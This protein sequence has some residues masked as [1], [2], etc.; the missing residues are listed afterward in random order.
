[1][2]TAC[3]V[4][5]SWIVLV[6]MLAACGSNGGS[7]PSSTA[8]AAA[9]PGSATVSSAPSSGPKAGQTDTDWGRIWDSLPPRFL[10]VPGGTPDENAAGEPVSAVIVF[11]GLQPEFAARFLQSR[12][13]NVGYTMVGSIEPL[14]DGSFV[15]EMTGRPDGCAIQATAT[16]TGGVTT[17]RILYGADCPNG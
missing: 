10:T 11:D 7:T 16:P 1:M 3:R 4:V 6:F 17:V 13:E 12:L 15:L 14:E 8:T 2:T 9:S 5:G